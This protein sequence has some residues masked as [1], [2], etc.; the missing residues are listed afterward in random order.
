MSFKGFLFIP[1][2]S[3]FVITL[4]LL[5]A[6]LALGCLNCWA[7]TEDL[8][9]VDPMKKLAPNN[10]S[11]FIS[12]IFLSWMNPIIYKGFKSPLNEDDLT[13]LPTK[14]D[15]AENVKSFQYHYKQYLKSHNIQFNKGQ[16][17]AKL[18][19][20]FAKT[21]GKRFLLANVLALTHYSITFLGPQILKLLISLVEDKNEY[22]W[23]GYFFSTLLLCVYC[24]STVF[25]T[26][27]LVQMYSIAISVSIS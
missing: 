25:F 10:F 9:T 15:V 13:A 11:S 26:S 8:E 12:T 17:Q 27:Y 22:V 18:W 1:D 14:V 20:P 19:I 24:I 2:T 23:K 4:L 7:D 5:P 6:S 3:R 21:F 16:K